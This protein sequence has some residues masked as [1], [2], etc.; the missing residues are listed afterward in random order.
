MEEILAQQR[1]LAEPITGKAFFSGV[2]G[3]LVRLALAQILVNFLITL[4]GIGLLNLLFY[5][6]AI[7]LLMRFMGKTVAGSQYM[8]KE[9][10]LILQKQLGDSTISVVEI[11]AAQV[12]SIRPVYRADRLACSYRSVSV[13]DASA[14][15][16]MRMRIAFGMS[17]FS[18]KKARKIAGKTAL[19][20]YA[21]GVV[22]LNEGKRHIC[23][24]CPDEAFLSAL[25]ARFPQAFGVDERTR[26]NTPVTLWLQALERAFPQL[27]AFVSP[28]VSAERTQAACAEIARQKQM[29]KDRQK[30]KKTDQTA[31]ADQT[32]AS[33]TM[34][35]EEAGKTDEV[36]D[37]TL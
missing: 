36:Q 18:A 26:E 17:L 34:D 2:F 28:L 6:Y 24:F 10:L 33:D 29:K 22:Y 27:Y 32:S 9:D 1:K 12:Q 35:N 5:L 3:V 20:A 14:A 19:D 30:G 8:L 25:K 16:P 4:T 37:D 21:Y 31:D 11:P 23:V 13:I 7:V 15:Q